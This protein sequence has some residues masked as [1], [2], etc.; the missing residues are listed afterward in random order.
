MRIPLFTL[1]VLALAASAQPTKC[2]PRLSPANNTPVPQLSV[3][4]AAAT[5]PL[6][7][8]TD[9]PVASVPASS[10]VISITDAATTSASDSDS[11]PSDPAPTDQSPTSPTPDSTPAR[12]SPN[13]NP[14]PHLPLR[15]NILLTSSPLDADLDGSSA[16]SQWIVEY[17]NEFRS[18][19]GAPNI[20]WSPALAATQADHL[21]RCEYAHFGSDNLATAWSSDST[22]QWDVD[23]LLDLWAGEWTAHAGAVDGPL[24]HFTLMVWKDVTEVGCAW[25]L[26]C[27]DPGWA[28][29]VYFTCKYS[30]PGNIVGQEAA[31]V[32]G[33]I[34]A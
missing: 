24:D 32:G 15:Q 11:T 9:V 19:F 22:K 16:V 7:S 6:G 8:V 34:G 25:T 30:P 21:S 4:A 28:Q 29:R 10:A 20:T 1:L 31:E 26:D 3:S 5:V 2:R 12:P 23:E 27:A 13:P 33:Y 17:H 14:T 18:E